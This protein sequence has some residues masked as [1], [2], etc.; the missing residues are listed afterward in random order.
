MKKGS[1]KFGVR[2]EIKNLNSF[3]SVNKAIKYE[4]KEQAKII[5]SGNSVKQS[6]MIWNEN[7]NKTRVTREKEDAHDYRYFPDPDLPPLYISDSNIKQILENMPEMPNQLISRLKKMYILKQ[8]DL[9]F[10]VSDKNIVAYFEDVLKYIS[11]PTLVLNWIRVN[12]MEIVNRDKISIADFRITPVRLSEL[13][14][15]FNK[16]KIT[17]ENANKIFETML[18]TDQ[19]AVNIMKELNLEILTSQD[20]LNDIIQE[21]IKKFP[22]EL[23]RLHNGEDKLIKFF[24]GQIMKETKGKYP[25]NLIIKILEEIN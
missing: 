18:R 11:E 8:E 3:R 2:R 25:P 12:V 6:T 21:T 24:M 19:S 5:E 4:V 17:K 14:K 10:L 9:L 13:L 16:K 15:L 23:K 7:E 20:D 1:S 22:D